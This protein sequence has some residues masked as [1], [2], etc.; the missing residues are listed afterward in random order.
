VEP[1][2]HLLSLA[3]IKHSTTN[4]TIIYQRGLTRIIRKGKP[5]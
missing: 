1:T 5:F 3:T 2:T 4:G